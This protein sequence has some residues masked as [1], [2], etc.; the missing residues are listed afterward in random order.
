MYII[1]IQ[2]TQIFIWQK[3]KR[4]L[5]SEHHKINCLVL[6]QQTKVTIGW[7]WGCKVSAREVMWLHLS[8]IPTTSESGW[9]DR[10]LCVCVWGAR[11]RREPSGIC[12]CRTEIRPL[13]TQKPV[14]WELVC[15]PQSPLLTCDA[16]HQR[17]TTGSQQQ[18]TV[19]PD[20]SVS[21][22]TASSPQRLPPE[23]VWH[24][25]RRGRIRADLRAS[26]DH[27]RL[28]GLGACRRCSLT[29][30]VGPVIPGHPF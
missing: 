26:D 21:A 23:Q 15:R 6:S 3:L 1:F 10:G 13:P 16:I 29:A 12:H 4:Y 19:Y 22:P 24:V 9:S 11:E 2:F 20:I 28:S 18:P 25:C 27:R 5:Q 8:S 7:K 30:C 14:S 17:T